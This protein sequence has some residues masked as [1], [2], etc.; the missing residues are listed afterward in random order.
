M[1]QQYHPGIPWLFWAAA[2]DGN[3]Y[4]V[5]DSR[6]GQ[7]Y[8]APTWEAVQQFAADHSSSGRGLGDLFHKITSFFGVKR[9]G[10]CAHRQV[11]G[12]AWSPWD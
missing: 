10:D 8:Y 11:Q 12:N 4:F 2:P 9:C 1:W 6:D 3:G 5:R 7:E